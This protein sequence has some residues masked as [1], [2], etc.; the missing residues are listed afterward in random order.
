MDGALARIHAFERALQGRLATRTAR[1]R[2]GT[3]YLNERFPRRWHSNFLWVDRALGAVTAQELAADVDDVFGR[4]GLD[5]RV[6]WVEDAVQGDRLTPGLEA[7][8]YETERNVVMV[9]A[10]E[11]DRWTDHRAEEIDL[12]AATTFAVASNLESPD[13]EDPADARML[14]GFKGELLRRVGARFFGARDGGEIVA[15]CDLY[16][17]GDVAQIEDVFTLTAHRGGGLARAAVLAAVR[18]A[19]DAGADLLFLG[20][21]DED[22]PKHLYAKLGFDVVGRSVDFLRKPQ[23][24][25]S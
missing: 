24:Q 7:L 22:W 4:A 19:R 16:R 20:A 23:G 21:D 9:Q 14:A 8:G 5:H 12:P 25:R 18:A 15:G 2:F 3:A 10:R 1:A 17:I 6:I 13:T 11:P